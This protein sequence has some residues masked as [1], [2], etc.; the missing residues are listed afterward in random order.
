MKLDQASSAVQKAGKCVIDPRFS[1]CMKF[2]DFT[3]MLCLMYTAIVTPLEVSFVEPFGNPVDYDHELGM[4][5]FLRN[6]DTPREQKVDTWFVLNR[7]LDGVFV[8]DMLLQFFVACAHA[9]APFGCR[10]LPHSSC[11]AVAK[12]LL[13]V[14]C[15]VRRR[16]RH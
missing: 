5:G 15:L 2:W 8:I 4:S 13:P 16:G 7:I 1:T 14:F 10:R 12:L 9:R 11:A 3:T 6:D